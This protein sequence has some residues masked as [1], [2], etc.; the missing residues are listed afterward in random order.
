M[1]GDNLLPPFP[2]FGGKRTIANTVWRALGEPK[3][4]IEPFCFSAAVLLAAPKPASLEV[5]G[6]L[7][8][9]VANF[10]RAVVAQAAEVARFA[11]YPVSHVDLGARHVWMMGERDRLAAELQDP[12][13]PGDAKVAG[14]W[15]WGQ[16]QWIG[17]GWCE[18]TGKVPHTSDAGRGV[19]A[20]GKVPHTSD[21]GR[22]VQATGQVPLLGNAG[23]GADDY[24]PWTSSGRVAMRWLRELADRME[25]VRV[26]HGAWNRCLNSH[27]GGAETAVF[28]DPPYKAYEKLYGAGGVGV[29]AEAEAWAREN[30][31]LRVVLCGHRGDYELPGWTVHE[32]DRGRMTY[33]GSKTTAEECLW[34]SPACLPL[35][36]KQTTIFDRL[37]GAK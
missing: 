29:A 6:D 9:F 34:L 17:S 18:W 35:L 21:A 12:N 8:G 24:E 30:A 5:I 28:L 15:L 37:G 27:Y 16:C 10:W 33:A 25:R 20:T 36:A 1:S 32:W 2:A 4:Y 7:N 26:V 19:Q 3:Q 13:W 31:G 14:W 11:D 22:G 23:R